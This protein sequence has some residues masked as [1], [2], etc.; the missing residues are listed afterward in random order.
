MLT[1]Q[2]LNRLACS[3]PLTQNELAQHTA[4]HPAGLS[5]LLAKLETD[6][7]VSRMR[8]T[9]DHRRVL[10]TITPAGR[11]SSETWRPWVRGAAAESLAVLDP[12]DRQQLGRILCKLLGED[13]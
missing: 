1:W 8:D 11:A 13:G 7:Q 10:V 6:G 2:V 9:T 5:R 4:Q 12:E 3:G